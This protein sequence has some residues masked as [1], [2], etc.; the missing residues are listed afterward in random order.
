MTGAK[1]MNKSPFMLAKGLTFGL[2]WI[3][4]MNVHNAFGYQLNVGQKSG[5]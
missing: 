4:A 5:F 1:N 3:Q 2:H